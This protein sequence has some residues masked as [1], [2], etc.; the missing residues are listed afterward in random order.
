MN[1]SQAARSSASGFVHTRDY[2]GSYAVASKSYAYPYG[3][4]DPEP[5]QNKFVQALARHAVE[6]IDGVRHVRQLENWLTPDVELALRDRAQQRK[7]RN[8]MYGNSPARP[9]YFPGRAHLQMIDA[10]TYEAVVTIRRG[11]HV[12][13]VAIRLTW[14]RNRWRAEH[15]TVL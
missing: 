15:L 8:H 7:E 9:L 6:V 14:F 2:R 5:P 12:F 1:Y 11:E 13:A 10:E 3:C 4:S